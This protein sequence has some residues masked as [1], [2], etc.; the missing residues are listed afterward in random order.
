M[1]IGHVAPEGYEGRA[2]CARESDSI[3]ID[4]NKRLI[5]LNVPGEVTCLWKAPKPRYSTGVFAKYTKL[6]STASRGAITHCKTGDAS[7]SGREASLSPSDE[8][9]RSP[10]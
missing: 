1:V 9:P 5:Q 2:D 10:S 3:T 7:S 8:E 6:I 4:A